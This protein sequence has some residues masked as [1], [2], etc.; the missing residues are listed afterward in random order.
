MEMIVLI[1][2]QQGETGTRRPIGQIAINGWSFLGVAAPKFLLSPLPVSSPSQ[3]PGH[4]SPG[5]ASWLYLANTG[6]T[7]EATE[8]G[9]R[10]N[11]K[12][13]RI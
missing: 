13:P 3:Q 1:Q 12:R 8:E 9:A 4:A 6:G 5:A 10:W 2:L 7:R 11:V